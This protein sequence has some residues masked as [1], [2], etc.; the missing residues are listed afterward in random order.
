[1]L[2]SIRIRK[3]SKWP[4]FNVLAQYLRGVSA[5]N[6]GCRH[7]LRYDSPGTDNATVADLH[8][9]QDQTAPANEA[10]LAD[11]CMEIESARTVMAKYAT[12]KRKIAIFPNMHAYRIGKVK[13]RRKGNLASGVEVHPKNSTEEPQANRNQNMAQCT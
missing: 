2:S 12:F 10:V 11:P 4:H 3:S 8:P 9:R 7:G 13:F 6:T 1:M 5:H